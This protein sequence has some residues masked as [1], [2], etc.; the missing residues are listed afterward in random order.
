MPAIDR[1]E[2]QQK[3]GENDVTVIE[4]LDASQYRKFHL[5]TAINIP[6]DD[7]FDQQVAKTLPDKKH[8]VALYCMD[9]DCPASSKAAERMETLGYSRVYDYEDGKMDWKQAGLRIHK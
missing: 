8:P 9:K 6:F 4:V 5:P 3:M 7:Q 1:N 2:L